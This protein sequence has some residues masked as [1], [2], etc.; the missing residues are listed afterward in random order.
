MTNLETTWTNKLK[1]SPLFNMSLSSK[2]LFH[3]NFLAWLCDICPESMSIFF[4]QNLDIPYA[5][6]KNI[7]REK[8]NIDISFELGNVLIIIENKVKSISY[9]EQLRKYEQYSSQKLGSDLKEKKYILLTLKTS[10]LDKDQ[11]KPWIPIQYLDLVG[12]METLLEENRI[13]NNYH[14]LII[15][16]YCQFIRILDH[17]IVDKMY[18]D[19]VHGNYIN[20]ANL[21]DKNTQENDFLLKLNDIK[22]HDFFQKGLFENFA[23]K[24]YD[25][26]KD[27]LKDVNI[28]YGENTEN[29]LNTISIYSG[30]T[31]SQGLLDIKYSINDKLT[32]GIQIQGVQYRHQLEGSSSDL[33]T[34]NAIDLK[35]KNK[36]FHFENI[37]DR[38]IYPKSDEKDFNQFKSTNHLF[39]YRSVKILGLNNQ[40]LLELIKKDVQKMLYIKKKDLI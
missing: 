34:K 11:L 2:E 12:Y 21:Y 33:V 25:Q 17:E 9:I 38:E 20:L 26:L 7:K 28:L 39:L 10:E 30:L 22:M 29:L 13:K 24:V 14:A 16:D 8:S 19:E 23:K 40:E 32:I 4:C 36:W 35:E 6:I 37:Y 27:S 18:I 5:N 3:S 1:K 15:N 31:R